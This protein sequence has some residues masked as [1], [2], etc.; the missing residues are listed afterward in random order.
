MKRE[1]AVFFT[2]TGVI[3]AL[4]VD[5]ILMFGKILEIMSIFEKLGWWS[6]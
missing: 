3:L 6:C 5:D 2:E 1:P 4:H